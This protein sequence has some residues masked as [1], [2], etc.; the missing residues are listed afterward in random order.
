MEERRIHRVSGATVGA[1]RF[2]HKETLG[3]DV[4]PGKA[5][6]TSRGWLRLIRDRNLYG[7]VC[8]CSETT[9]QPWLGRLVP[10]PEPPEH[11]NACKPEN[12]YELVGS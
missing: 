12:S 10:F 2:F 6:L 1:P 5:D 11:R 4:R 3:R 9:F 8:L 7:C